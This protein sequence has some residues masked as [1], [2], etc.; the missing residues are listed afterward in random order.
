[1]NDYR[2]ASKEWRKNNRDKIDAYLIEK[3]KDI[4]WVNIQRLRARKSTALHRH[5]IK[6][7]ELDIEWFTE[8]YEKGCALTGIPFREVKYEPGQRSATKTPF[9][10]SID[11]IDSSK[12]YTKENSQLILSSM[13]QFKGKFPI[14]DI[15]YI[16]EEFLKHHEN[17]QKF[18]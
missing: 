9:T 11:R 15:I 18:S 1:M 2:K 5:G 6:E 17:T 13:N 10:V 12:G 8:N 16:A 14:D 3:H 4:R 7:F